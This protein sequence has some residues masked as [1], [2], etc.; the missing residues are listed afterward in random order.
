MGTTP[1]KEKN[2][3]ES[4]VRILKKLLLFLKIYPKIAQK[5]MTSLVSK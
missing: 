5:Y 1:I 2:S 3:C 4:N